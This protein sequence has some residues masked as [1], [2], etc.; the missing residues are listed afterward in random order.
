MPSKDSS[1]ALDPKWFRLLHSCRWPFTFLAAT[2]LLVSGASHL[3]RHPIPVRIDG[4][5][6]LDR[7]AEPIQV[8]AESPLRVVGT[9]V[10]ANQGAI[11]VAAEDIIFRRPITVQASKS[12][13]VTAERAIPVH[14]VEPVAV[15]AKAAIPVKA[16]QPIPVSTGGPVSARVVVDAVNTPIPVLASEPLPV[17][18]TLEVTKIKDPLRVNVR[19]LLFPFSI[20]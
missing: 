10:V 17:E 15:T 16:T 7:V 5:V 8:Q 2:W 3:L 14:A 4:G 18:G 12:I 1:S 19:S 9:V 13:P 6:S 11:K 20:P